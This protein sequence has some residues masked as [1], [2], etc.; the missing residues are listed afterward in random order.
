MT[1]KDAEQTT[2][3]GAPL[4]FVL[5]PFGKK[6]VPAGG[7]ELDFDAVYERALKPGI[8][9]AGLLPIRADEE[10]LGGIIHK[11][12][13]ERLL[14]CDYAVADL[15]AANANV[16][17]ELGVRHTAR[18]YSTLL[19]HAMGRPLPFD[20]A[21]LRSL[22]YELGADN[23]FSDEASQALRQEVGRRLKEKRA[24]RRM[25]V[26]DRKGA[27]RRAALDS[28]LFQLIEEWKPAK[29]PEEAAASFYTQAEVT[30][31]T[32]DALTRVRLLAASESTRPQARRELDAL[33][34]SSL[35]DETPDGV[36][37]AL[38]LAHR[39]L[40]NWAEMVKVFQKLSGEIQQQVKARQLL[41][42]AYGRLSEDQ[43]DPERAFKRDE[44]LRLLAEVEKDEGPS[45]ET[46]GLRGRIYKA[47]WREAREAHRLSKGSL[48]DDAL[49]AYRKGF[50]TDPRDFY[51]GINALILLLA[52][53]TPSALD[54]QSKLLPVVRF[55][56]ERAAHLD[57]NDYW[58]R[59]TRLELAVLQGD[60]ESALEVAS[61]ACAVPSEAWQRQTTVDTLSLL[62]ELMT[63][64]DL[65][66]V[67]EIKDELLATGVEEAG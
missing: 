25:P 4:C 22:G 8:E 54:E 52:K 40:G 62:Q 46:Y 42:F 59:A 1:G 9:D 50:E 55:S 41:A 18:P 29:L 65:S 61:A 3:A 19:V 45:S 5:M 26:I 67:K 38:L 44:A 47:R 48:L 12:M 10:A 34:V 37:M 53:G 21:P 14:I 56:V 58:V 24:Q 2:P 43:D 7:P 6:P 23:Q 39:S 15:T 49:N 17:Y 16:L 27:A 13:F 36:T 20:V 28:P 51:P 31:S 60:Q 30:R 57:T 63:D 33:G 66:W 11:P 64:T 32:I 35:P